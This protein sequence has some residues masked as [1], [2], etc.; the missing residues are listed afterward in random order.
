[1]G[2]INVLGAGIF[3]AFFFFAVFVSAISEIRKD[4]NDTELKEISAE[5]FVIIFLVSIYSMVATI[6]AGLV[7]WVAVLLKY[8]LLTGILV[9]LLLILVIFCLY[10]FVFKRR[11]GKEQ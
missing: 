4:S 10:K 3:L 7:L 8:S 5:S 1:M 9:D 6:V 11:Y 2:M